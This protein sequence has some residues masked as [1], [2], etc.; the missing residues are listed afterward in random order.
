MPVPNPCPG[1]TRAAQN[2]PDLSPSVNGMRFLCWLTA[3]RAGFA[4]SRIKPKA[5]LPLAHSCAH[6]VASAAL[7]LFP[8][9]KA[10]SFPA[11]C[12]TFPS[13]SLLGSSL[14][15]AALPAAQPLSPEAPSPPRRAPRAGQ[16]QR[17]GST[18]AA[19]GNEL[20]ENLGSLFLPRQCVQPSSF[21]PEGF[22]PLEFAVLSVGGCLHS[23]FHN[24]PG[25]FP[26]KCPC[27]FSSCLGSGPSALAATGSD[28]NY[29]CSPEH[30][31][32]GGG[33]NPVA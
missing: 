30:G 9:P 18:A 19:V 7:T 5:E 15:A 25:V 8:A 16:A 24:G 17:R 29:P 33:S 3:W 32:G 13:L 14:P 31:A 12:P 4:L 11:T 2:L 10:P 22:S 6:P 28:P 23:L 27:S 26:G 1:P 21:F 20:Q